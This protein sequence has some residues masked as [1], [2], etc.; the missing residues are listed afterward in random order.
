MRTSSPKVPLAFLVVTFAVAIVVA[1]AIVY[2]GIN[3]PLGG[4][5]P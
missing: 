5:I 3:G 4:P 2:L 1:V